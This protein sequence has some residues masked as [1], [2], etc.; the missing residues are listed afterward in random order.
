MW[1]RKISRTYFKETT[2]E[3]TLGL[4]TLV[5]EQ[6]ELSCR[7]EK[8]DERRDKRESRKGNRRGDLNAFREET[9]LHLFTFLMPPPVEKFLKC[10]PGTQ[11]TLE[12]T[13]ITGRG[14]DV[15]LEL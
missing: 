3:G 12:N 10:H 4:K 2:G 13:F 14:N 9:S 11:E 15:P 7:T 8:R 6:K 5:S 1:L